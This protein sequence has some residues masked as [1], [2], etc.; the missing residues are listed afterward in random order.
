MVHSTLSMT[1]SMKPYIYD[2]LI[3]LGILIGLGAS[4]F[5]FST[6]FLLSIIALAGTLILIWG[7]FIEPQLILITRLSISL[8]KKVCPFT[9][10]VLTDIHAGPYKK[11]SFVERVVQKTIQLNPD[12][13]VI[14]GDHT[15]NGFKTDTQEIEYLAPIQKLTQRFPV[16]AVH[17]NH[18]YGLSNL[19]T[20][21]PKQMR[22][23]DVSEHNAQVLTSYGVVYLQNETREIE[24]NGQ[25]IIFFGGDEAWSGNLDYSSLTSTDPNIPKIALVHNPGYL[26]LPHP[27]SI[28]LTIAGHTH[29]GQIR[30]PIIGP[31]AK[32]DD[33][34]PKKF[35]SGLHEPER[36]G[37]YLFVSRGLGESEPRAR[38]FSPP[39]IALL[40]IN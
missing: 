29:D 31:L 26:Y 36:P 9:I 3:I 38:L 37:E 40:T 35:Y 15:Y 30:L 21:H 39:E 28:D 22:F 1:I 6:N 16:Y 32:A 13:V 20:T 34:L 7:S 17:G 27:P 23:A 8:T 11:T 5:F 25:K 24:I 19:I 2:T 4:V 33:T 18:E 10:A 14:V 12:I